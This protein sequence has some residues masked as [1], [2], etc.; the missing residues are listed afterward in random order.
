VIFPVAHANA[1]SDPKND[2]RAWR[3]G[4]LCFIGRWDATARDCR[5]SAGSRVGISPDVSSRGLMEPDVVELKDSRVLVVWR[6]SNTARTPGRK[7]FALSSDGGRTLTAPLEWKYDDGS[8]FY[9]P[10]SFHRFL[11]HTGSR[12]LFWIG[13]ICGAPPAGNGPRH[14]LVIAEV[15]EASGMLKRS[16]VTAIAVREP[17]QAS[18]VQFSNFSLLEDRESHAIEL[19]LT[20]IGG[21]A[22]NV[23]NADCWKYT[24]KL[25]AK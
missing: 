16:T 24:L 17:E 6:G 18:S 2:Q 5:W 9:S 1:A 3:M 4:S 13:N 15:D 14:P 11:R 25:E 10:S 21:E 20:H 12:K 8:S 19:Y 7:W 23:F 22:K